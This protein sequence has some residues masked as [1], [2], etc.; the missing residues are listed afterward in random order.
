MSHTFVK[1]RGG[2]SGEPSYIPLEPG[3]YYGITYRSPAFSLGELVV[4]F[5]YENVG[6]GE[7][8]GSGWT[9][10]IQCVSL[11]I[12]VT[13]DEKMLAGFIEE[14]EHDDDPAVRTSRAS[15]LTENGITFAI[16][17]L[18][19]ML[20][21]DPNQGVKAA[22][23][24]GLQTLTNEDLGV[25]APWEPTPFSSAQHSARPIAWARKYLKDHPEV[26]KPS[27][28]SLENLFSKLERNPLPRD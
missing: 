4:V 5:T 21:T 14:M 15:L 8:G 12:K 3:D 23:A 2:P 11:P 27:K 17:T 9:G 1:G 10:R 24:W 13:I 6:D 22:A 16:P 25:P 19:R 7:E 26:M 28:K 20:E 18:L